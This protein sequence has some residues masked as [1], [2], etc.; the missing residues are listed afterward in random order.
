MAR[1]EFVGSEFKGIGMSEFYG[2]PNAK[3][4]D[5]KHYTSVI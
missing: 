4:F 5:G 2:G 3:T 1:G